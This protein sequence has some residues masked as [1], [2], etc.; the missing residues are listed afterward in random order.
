MQMGFKIL[1]Q[2]GL[3]VSSLGCF[4]KIINQYII[5]SLPVFSSGDY[6]ASTCWNTNGKDNASFPFKLVDRN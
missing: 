2:I 6:I 4:G 1:V 5:I 3:Y